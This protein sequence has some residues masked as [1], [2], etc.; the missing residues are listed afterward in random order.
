MSQDR[1][2]EI[3]SDERFDEEALAGY[4]RTHVPELEGDMVVEQFHGGS[5]NLTYAV[6]IGAT[7]CV[8]RRPPLGP[9]APRSHDMRREFRGLDALAPLYPHSPRPI[10]LCEDE[11]VIGAVFFLMERRNGVVIRNEWPES[12]PDD[13][14]LRRRISE[15]MIDAL[16]DLHCVDTSRPEVAGLGKPKG[17]LER[18]ITGWAG[19][20]ERAKTRELT[21]MDALRDWLSSNMPESKQVSV[22]HNDYKLDN[23]IYDLEDPGRL[24]GVFDW[25]MVTLGDPLVDLGTLLGYWSQASD[26]GPRGA[27]G[28][29]VSKCPGFLT[30]A[31]LTDRYQARTGFDV[32]HLAFYEIFALFKTAVVVE[33]IYVRWVKGQTKDSRF[34]ALGALTPVLAAAAQE[35]ISG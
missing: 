15:S 2:G 1:P 25:D 11:S 6:T 7:E 18:Q 27:T 32:S 20:W 10:H 29:P 35:C 13:E 34:E 16:A 14:R 22:L 4:L 12:L 21:E 23:T 28:T 24:V 5:A 8:L 3:R 30:R 9:V 17:F 33:Q 26:T 31:E 19:R